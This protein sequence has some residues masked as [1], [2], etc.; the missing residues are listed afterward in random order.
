M[1]EMIERAYFRLCQAVGH[2]VIIIAAIY[3]LSMTHAK[4]FVQ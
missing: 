1:G 3:T 4:Y 2:A